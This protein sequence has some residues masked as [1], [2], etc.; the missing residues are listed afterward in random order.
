MQ[1]L[2]KGSKSDPNWPKPSLEDGSYVQLG[3]VH[4]GDKERRS[5]THQVGLHF[6]YW[7]IQFKMIK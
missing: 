6:P 4:N 2:L 3:M 7:L 1:E 5:I